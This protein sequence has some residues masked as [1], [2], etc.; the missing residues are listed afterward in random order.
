MKAEITCNKLLSRFLSYGSGKD[1][2]LIRRAFKLA[3]DVHIH[4]K[5]DNGD[6]YI[7]HPL[8]VAVILARFHLDAASI[9]T[10]LLHDVIEDTDVTY[11]DI[12]SRFGLTIANLVDGVTKLTRLELQSDRTKQ[13][14]NFRKLVLAMSKDIRVLLV[15][16]ADRLH[17]MRTLHLIQN[18]DRRRR[19]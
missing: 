12:K 17:N 15:K 6:P 18:I 7:T 4:Q 1:E 2:D 16:L 8:A 5:R 13:A 3:A 11:E 9:C 19:I 10:A 14:E